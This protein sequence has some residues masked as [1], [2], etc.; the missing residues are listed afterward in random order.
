LPAVRDR[1]D[2][3]FS[4]LELKRT[5]GRYT[6]TDAGRYTTTT[7]ADMPSHTA[8]ATDGEA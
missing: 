3:W 8:S 5:A 7:H 1:C 6:T 2:V 4:L